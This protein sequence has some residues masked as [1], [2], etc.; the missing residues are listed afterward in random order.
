MENAVHSLR[1]L[2]E[3]AHLGSLWH[4]WELRSRGGSLTPDYPL[5]GVEEERRGILRVQAPTEC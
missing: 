2:V 5:N 1:G 4:S 3:N